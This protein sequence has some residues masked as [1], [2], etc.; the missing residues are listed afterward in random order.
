MKQFYVISYDITDDRRRVKVMKTLK[1]FGQ[2]VQYSVFEC[3]LEPRQLHDL[4]RRLRRWVTPQD[5]LRFYSL[6]QEDTGRIQVM[7]LGNVT[8]D[9]FVI[10]H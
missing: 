9:P 6:C 7:G 10:I 3:W 8:P 5:S 2:R 4:Q 1:N